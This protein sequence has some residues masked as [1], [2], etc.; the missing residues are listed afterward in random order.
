MMTYL[1]VELTSRGAAIHHLPLVS[2]THGIS[3]QRV[4]NWI[5]CHSVVHQR[6]QLSR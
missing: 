3:M 6:Y 2:S 5:I 1:I 4:C